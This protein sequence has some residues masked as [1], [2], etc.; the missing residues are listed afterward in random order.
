MIFKHNMTGICLLHL[1]SNLTHFRVLSMESTLVLISAERIILAKLFIR[2]WSLFERVREQFGPVWFIQFFLVGSKWGF[3]GLS[4]SFAFFWG[5]GG[6]SP[7]F[8]FPRGWPCLLG[9]LGGRTPNPCI[10]KSF[11]FLLSQQKCVLLCNKLIDTLDTLPS[12]KSL[13]SLSF[14]WSC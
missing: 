5:G 3:G 10:D 1:W 6:C 9:C 11:F 12:L 4:I 14:V 13:V 8:S 7:F 2:V